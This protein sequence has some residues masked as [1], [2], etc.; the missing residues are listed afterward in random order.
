M[1][2]YVAVVLSETVREE[3]DSLLVPACSG[4]TIACSFVPG[5]SAV[6]SV[7]CSRPSIELTLLSLPD[8]D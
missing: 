8:H 3:L 4:S 1:Y 5:E 7:L 6:L 2:E